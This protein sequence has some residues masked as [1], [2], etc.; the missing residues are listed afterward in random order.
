MCVRVIANDREVVGVKK[1]LQMGRKHGGGLQ[2]R[3]LVRVHF[4]TAGGEDTSSTLDG[5]CN[6]RES[7][8]LQK[9]LGNHLATVTQ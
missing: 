1:A 9:A 8:H 4:V 2:I 5:G 7:C 3:L 6:R